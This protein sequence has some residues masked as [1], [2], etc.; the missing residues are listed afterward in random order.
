MSQRDL[1]L[2]RHGEVDSAFK[3]VCYGAMDV[4]LSKRGFTESEQLAQRIVTHVQPGAVYH[5]GLSRTQTLAHMIVERTSK[6][7]SV[8]GDNRLRE[9]NYGAWQGISWDQAY[10]SDPK[11]F[12]DLIERPSTYRPPEGESTT[13]MQLRIVLWYEELRGV[14]D[15]QS[16]LRH[17]AVTL[18]ISHS[19][20]IAALAGHLQ[21]LHPRDWHPWMIKPLSALRISE[22]RHR[23][24]RVSMLSLD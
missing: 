4:P 2:V 15:S 21:N 10:A 22:N 5:S 23:P 20:P 14:M 18:A 3:G 16:P 6:G 11:H 8:I 13:E 1:I 24:P 19:G 12:H 9:R 7:V 17:P